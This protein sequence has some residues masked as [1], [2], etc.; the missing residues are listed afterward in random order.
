M[1]ATGKA[2]SY[3]RAG[4]LPAD[5]TSFL[6][7]R[8]EITEIKRL[9]STSRVVTLTGPGG[10]GKTRLAVRVAEDLRRAFHDRVW[11]VE[12]A[13]LRD[14]ALLA[15]TVGERIGVH[16][17]SGRSA[18]DAIVEHLPTGPVLLV[19]DNCEHLVDE[20]AALV[21]ALV[22][23]CGEL[24]VLATSR[25]SLG[26]IGE[27]LYPVAPFRVPDPQRV[28]ALDKLTRY[29]SVRLFVERATAVRPEFSLGEDNCADVARVCHELDGIPLAIELTAVRL[30]SLS[31]DQIAERLTER[32]LL[33]SDGARNAPARQRSLRTLIDWSHDLC[34][35]QERTVWARAAV[36]SGSF[37][38]D[39]V[40]YVASDGAVPPDELLNV[41]DSLVDKSVFMREE[42]DG[43]VRYRLLETVREYGEEKLDE[44]GDG[45]AVRRRHRDWYAGLVSRFVTEWQGHDQAEW[46][47]RLRRDHANIRV[48]LDFCASEPG[49]ATVGLRMATQLDDYWGI[50]GLHTEARHWLD[51]MLPTAPPS[52]ERVA[53]LRMDGWFALL[54][55]DLEPG[56]RLLAEATQ[57]AEERGDEEETA[58]LIHGRGMVALFTGELAQATALF[59]D[60]LARFRAANVRRGE[61][62]T[63]FI[64]GLTVGVSGERDRGL[65]VLTECLDMCAGIA[66]VFWRSY[67]LWSVA[68]VEVLYGSLARAESAGKEALQLQQQ[69]DNR[70]AMAFSLDTLA[71]IVERH[72]H[73]N[74]AAVL[75]GAASAV[76]Q[77]IGSAPGHYITFATAHDE[78]L[79]LTHQALGERAFAAAFERGRKMS[80][81]QAV[82]YALEIEPAAAPA[83]EPATPQT[84]LT[85]REHQI[86]ALVA[87]GLTNREIAAR[88]VI[89]Q[90]TAEGHVEHIMTKLGFSTRAQIAAW[91]A[92]LPGSDLD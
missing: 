15:N 53:A 85:R 16:D 6:G 86:A 66:D 46:V 14:A 29:P 57:L 92:A 32:Y 80:I 26:L 61:F 76:W 71:W 68:H 3:A 41:I 19:L 11:F 35:E 23:S 70:L 89:A 7:R 34:S 13:E 39:A 45:V 36:F 49:E 58:Y 81:D 79:A 83:A 78:H 9:L 62:F 20:V 5:T 2:R 30:R 67:A 75:F 28:R 91:M 33:L 4:Y 10:V 82:Q 37:A 88:L 18:V 8:R 47:R 38:L 56:Q 74:R 65:A 59:T 17:Q 60:A 1:T 50:R 40:E 43:S 73:H 25:Q 77:A 63:L 12:L 84:T 24:R 87:E 72:G 64:L 31:L 54:Q 27:S 52:H 51:Q 48:A 44:S 90:R 22:R 21:N 42:H 55:G 69:L